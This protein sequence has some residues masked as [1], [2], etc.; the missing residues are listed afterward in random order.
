[1]GTRARTYWGNC[2]WYEVVKRMPDLRQKRRALNPS[3]PSVAMCS[4]W[5]ENSRMLRLTF[6]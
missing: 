4:A 3:G 1:M 2:V 6:L 5:G